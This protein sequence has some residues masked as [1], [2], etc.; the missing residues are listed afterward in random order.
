MNIVELKPWGYLGVTDI[1][2]DARLWDS[3]DDEI[4]S[5]G[6]FEI[7]WPLNPASA[8]WLFRE[9]TTA[10]GAKDPVYSPQGT[11]RPFKGTR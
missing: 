7:D 6:D 3:Y 9:S 1:Y 4:L 2:A 5:I 11:L 10:Q 8:S